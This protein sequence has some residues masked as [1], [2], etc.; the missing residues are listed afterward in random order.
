MAPASSVKNLT[1]EVE[2][3]ATPFEFM[4]SRQAFGKFQRE[5]MKD[6]AM[7][8]NNFLLETSTESERLKKLFE[9]DFGLPAILAGPIMDELVGVRQ[10]TL[11][12]SDKS[13]RN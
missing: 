5:G 11:K 9:D 4:V 1:V 2:G 6:P 7:A 3:E 12:K 8:L 13:L 10:A